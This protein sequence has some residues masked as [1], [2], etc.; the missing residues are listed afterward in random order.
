MYCPLRSRVRGSEG[1]H[2]DD[3][4]ARKRPQVQVRLEGRPGLRHDLRPVQVEVHGLDG[5]RGARLEALQSRGDLLG[6]RKE[7]DRRRQQPEV[8]RLLD[9]RA[10]LCAGRRDLR[11]RS[12][13]LLRDGELVGDPTLGALVP[14]DT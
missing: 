7:R 10:P 5:F 4:L 2:P 14:S 13:G 11:G 6:D 9:G 12:V 1:D 8:A 3:V